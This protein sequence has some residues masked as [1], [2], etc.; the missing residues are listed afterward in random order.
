MK[1]ALVCT[2]PY[3][4]KLW[5]NVYPKCASLLRSDRSFC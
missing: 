4:N 1:T 2:V 5:L 3:A